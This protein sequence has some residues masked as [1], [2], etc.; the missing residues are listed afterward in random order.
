MLNSI[1]IEQFASINRQKKSGV[2]TVVGPS[3]RLR[4][5]LEEGD[6]VGLD[7]C[8]DK[9]LVL[10]QALLD[11][12]KLGQEMYQMVV[13]SRRLGKGSVADLL[14]RQQVVSDEEVAQVTRSMVEDTLVKCFST[15]HQEM[16]FDEQDD[17]S[18]FDFDNSAIRLRIGT[19]VLLNTVQSRVAEIDKVMNEVGGPDSVFTLS[20][21]ES[22]SVVLSDFEKHVLNF[23]DGRKTVEEIAIAFRESTL[24]MSRLLY[25]MAAKGVVRRTAAAGGVS[26]LRTAVQPTQ[27]APAPPSVGQI[28][29]VE[30]L[31]DFVPHRAQ[32]QPAGS[33]SALR[34]MLVAALLL[35]CA[36]GYLTI[37]AQRRS[38]ALD[39][40]SQALIDS[41]TA[42]RWDEAMTQVETAEAEA[43][44]DLQAL[45]RVKAL[46]QQLNEA[47]AT[48][49]AA[50]TKLVEEQN[51][52][53][54]QERLNNL[55]LSAQPL[56][57]RTALQSGQNT[58]KARSDRLLAQV[59][60]ALEGGQAAQ[61]MHLIS[62]AKGRESETASDY[63]A[64]WRLSSLERAG[65]SSL[66]LS[67]RTALV[68]Q[69]LATDPDA[70]QREQ[71]ERIRGDFARLQQ[72]TS[73]QVKT[74]R[75][76]AEQGAFVEVEAAWEQ[77]RLGDQLRG[78]PLAGEGDELKRLND[79]IAK[80]MRAL[81]AEGLSLIQDSDDV[82]VMGSF[83]TRVQQATGKWPQASNAESLRS[84]AQL[85]NELSGLGSE[86][87]AGDEAT[88]LDAWILE[89]QPPANI[90]TL[91]AGRSAR[92][93]GIESAA[94]LALE[95]ARGFARQNDWEANERMLKELLARPQW[96]R[97]SARTLAQQDLDSIASIRGQQQAWQ[98]ELRKAMLAGDT[99][100]SLAIAQKMGLRYLP[101]VV[102]SQP[103]G[104]DV[105]RDGK[106]IGTT[107]LI[108][109]MPA[110]ERAA[111]TLRVQRAGFDVVEV[112][113]SAAEG[114]WFLPVGLERTATGRFDLKMTVT[115]RPT[116]INDRLWI[117]SR[118]GA[119]SIAPGQPVQ[120]FA[121]E[122]P[123]TGD[124]IGQPLYAGALGTT[125]GVWYP[126]REAIAIRVG[127]NGIE[128]LA[129]AGRTDL[130]L[131]DYASEL[132]VGRRFIILAGIDGAL[133]ASDDRTPLAAWH[134]QPGATFV[135][136]PILHDDRVLAVRVDGSIDIH[137]P[138]DG[139][140]VTRHRLDGEVLSAWK[141]ADGV[142]CVTRI[143]HWVCQGENPPT[144]APLPQEIRSAGKGVLIT[145]DNHAWILSDA[146]WQD[147]GRFDGRP[148][149][150][151]LVWSGHAV[152]PIGKQ[153]LVVG[154]KGFV[155]PGGSEFLAP[156]IVGQQLAV[157]T[158]DGMVRFYEP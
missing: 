76:Q 154:P 84:L 107:P 150:V 144:R 62:T 129:I 33:N 42:G 140:L 99:T 118:Q 88:A 105:L 142:H 153:L 112:Q 104:A 16:V 15:T 108:L 134:G 136:G 24:N 50:I 67:Q 89:R 152:L 86:R 6:P 44:N 85:L 60:A 78:T 52:P 155:V 30:P 82:K 93:R 7:F 49:T 135:H 35:V 21:N 72:R 126:T 51:Y 83:A 2:L 102:H 131:V 119:A 63:L 127:K 125:D 22:G 132:I 87:K 57:L 3:Y 56:D 114:G 70:R 10:A 75:K 46:R 34:V 146:S 81:E 101:L 103:S 54:A 12:H 32:Q 113:G 138:D 71:I 98:E 111:V 11:F 117:A 13:E 40:T 36:I 90:A 58:F 91:V 148:T 139:K 47:L 20:E 147:V 100:T 53:T 27:E 124:V 38:V 97:T 109:D 92:L 80:E 9:D 121:F 143:S 77:S 28:T 133:H 43:G 116:A 122:N 123:G 45:D 145:P 68:N 26:R 19:S 14:R 137:L 141:A 130:P 158:Q 59:T 48:E 151:P 61:A 4:F 66:A 17:A 31:A 5:C 73:E 157:C 39:S 149:A 65:S 95:T 94:T 110:G 74:L 79:Q 120:R 18:T 29:A 25:G 41:M 37:M 156:A 96:Q 128:R 23:T 8:A 69:I 106:S 55:P 64:R 115:A 1:L